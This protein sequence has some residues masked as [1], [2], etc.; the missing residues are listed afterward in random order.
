M[1]GGEK[2]PL[3]LEEIRQLI[4]Y[5]PDTGLFFWLQDRNSHAG[6]AKAGHPAGAV[7]DGYLRITLHGRQYRAHRLAWLLMTGEFPPKGFE[8]DHI[9]RL[10]SDNRWCNLRLVSRSQNNMNAGLR[11]DN[12]SGVRGVSWA[13]GNQRWD[14]RITVNKKPILLGQYVVLEDAIAA[15]KAAERQYFGEH[16]PKETSAWHR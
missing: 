16:A 11:S 3:C 5:R 7:R 6:K 13:S 9:N 2:M 4:E 15:R 12:T 10:R 14:A 8:I 1:S